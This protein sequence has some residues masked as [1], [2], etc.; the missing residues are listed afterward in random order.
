MML[1][2]MEAADP[3]GG[4]NYENSSN[5]TENGPGFSTL[6]FATQHSVTTTGMLGR[7]THAQQPLAFYF[8]E[9]ESESI[10]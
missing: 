1:N 10:G 5:R 6:Q 9:P 8:H 3:R 4:D 7:S 2:I